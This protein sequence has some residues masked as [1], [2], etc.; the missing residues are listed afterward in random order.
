MPTESSD[1]AVVGALYDRAEVI[2]RSFGMALVLAVLFSGCG[3]EPTTG[4]DPVVSVSV[5][6]ATEMPF[7]GP[8]GPGSETISITFRWTVTIR[9]EGADGTIGTVRT[10]VR[11][12]PTG[13]SLSVAMGPES[14]GGVVKAG[15]TLDVAQQ[16][17]GFFAPGLYPGQWEG[18]AA[19]EVIHPSG[20]SETIEASFAFQ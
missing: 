1:Y 5:R 3:S 14:H 18:V 10:L 7:H 19:V 12:K 6:S 13:T 15:G 16:V 20:R 17:G 11:D 4:P 2:M 9:A 8:G